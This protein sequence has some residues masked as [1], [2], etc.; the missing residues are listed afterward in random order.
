MHDVFISYANQDK[1]TADAVCAM[2]ETNGIRCWIAPRDITPGQDWGGA[3]VQAIHQARVMVLVFSRHANESPQIKREVERA[4]SSELLIIPLRIENVVPQA[5]LEYFLGTP[6]WLDAITPPL[7]AHLERLAAVVSSFITEQARPVRPPTDTSDSS[8]DVAAATGTSDLD[9]AERLSW[10]KDN[11]KGGHRRLRTRWTIVAAAGALAVAVALTLVFTLPGSPLPSA[12]RA[13]AAVPSDRLAQ[14]LLKKG[15]TSD[16]LPS[17]VS[18]DGAPTVALV[19][20]QLVGLVER[21]FNP[22]SGPAA[23]VSIDYYVF[24]KASDADIFYNYQP[25]PGGYHVT[26]SF[27]ETGVGDPTRCATGYEAAIANRWDSSC[28]T[29]SSQVVSEVVVENS[30]DSISSDSGL[31]TVLVVDAVRHLARVASELGT[32]P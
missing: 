21:V 12:R 28:L 8:P 5:S 16:E 27:A 9:G 25:V 30:T 18:A 7:R 6:H 31:A 2:L 3:I 13:A 26:T 20:S 17:N 19:T 14:A 29:L 22:L 10:D 4:V 23:H 15:F 1:P 11:S 32:P 24:A